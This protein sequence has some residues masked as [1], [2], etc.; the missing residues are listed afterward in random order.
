MSGG[1]Y[2]IINLVNGMRYIGST[3]N[4]N[5]RKAN[6]FYALRHNKHSNKNLQSD[7]NKYGEKNFSFQVIEYVGRFDKLI[8]REQYYIDTLKLQYNICPV[9]GSCL[10]RVLTLRTKQKISESM[11]KIVPS[12]EKRQKMREIFTGRVFS[13]K[14]RELMSQA[15]IG[16]SLPEEV[17]EKIS[18]TKR[19][20]NN[21]NAKLTTEDVVKIKQLLGEGVSQTKLSKIYGV[22]YNVI[23]NIR[24]GRTWKHV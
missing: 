19:G 15:A 7:W 11:K 10:R 22:N 3:S 6:N 12:A 13:D 1:V 14:T 16:R 2:Q 18:K 9:A 24:M 4:L 17:K 23:N 5:K 20:E 21:P 8:E